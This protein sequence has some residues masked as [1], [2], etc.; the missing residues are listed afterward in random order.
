M[1]EL[2]HGFRFNDAV[3]R[4]LAIKRDEAVTE[5]SP[6]MKEEK[7]RSLLGG[8][9]APAADAPVAEAPAA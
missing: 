4:H 1:D 2:E 6:M 8:D 7:S 3:L 9:A 5:A